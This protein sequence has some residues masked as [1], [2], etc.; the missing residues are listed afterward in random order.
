MQPFGEK[1]E[2]DA[3]ACY[4]CS[5]ACDTKSPCACKRLYMHTECQL[6]WI[7]TSGKTTCSVCSKPFEN[8]VVEN[9]TNTDDES[10]RSSARRGRIA[11]AST[12]VLEIVLWTGAALI[13]FHT[14]EWTPTDAFVFCAFA[15][16]MVLGIACEVLRRCVGSGPRDEVVAL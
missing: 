4:V 15:A 1:E 2:E 16:V 5:E 13:A 6:Q 12:V 8:V 9:P 7:V 14:Y 11:V 3:P 10:V